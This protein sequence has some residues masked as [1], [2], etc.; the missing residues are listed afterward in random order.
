MRLNK[1]AFYGCTGLTSVTIPNSVTRIGDHAFEGCYKLIEV[2]N[3]SSL[4]ITAGSSDNGYV[5]CYAKN[6]YTNEG[7]SKLTEDENG[8][9]IYTDGDKKILVAY[10]GTNTELILPSYI[11]EIYRYAFYNC[12]G[13]TSITIP[14]S[15]TSIGGSAFYYGCYKL[16]DI[17]ITDIAAWC[18]ISGLGNLM[19][20]GSSNKNLYLNNELVTSITIPNGVTAIPSSAFRYCTGLTSVTIPDSVASIGKRAFSECAGLTSVKIPDS[21]TSID[22]YAFDV[23]TGLTSVTIGNS[24]T[25]IGTAVFRGCTGLT[26]ITIPDSVTSIGYDAFAY[27][28]G[29]TSITIPD[30]VTSIG[31]HA[32][33]GC[34][35]LIE[36]YNKSSLTITAGSS[37]NGY[38]ACYAKNVYTNEGGSKLTEDEN[39][40]VIYTDGDKKILVAYHGTNTE[41]ILPSY[42]TEIYQYAFYNYTRL[43]SVKIPDSVTSIGYSAFYKCISL[44]SITFNGTIAQWNAISK[45]SYWKYNVPNT[46]KIVCT[47]VTI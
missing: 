37:D 27:C 31:D 30:S 6:V 46:C 32:F 4:T 8:Y 40:Y 42:I 17:Y 34:Y 43:T 2:Y 13:L 1:G 26:N 21:V 35:K 47:D 19:G 9:V 10:H 16:Q 5:A 44:T 12:K 29:L 36:V 41:L 22:D 25:S 7:G 14:N 39:G 24:V 18:N 11:T 45:G 15:V 33:E 3:K 23:C 28:K 20:Y 38:V